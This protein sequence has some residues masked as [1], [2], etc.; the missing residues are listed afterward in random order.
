MD[1]ENKME[2]KADSFAEMFEDSTVV[3]DNLKPGDKVEAV[4]ARITDKWIFLDLGAKSEGCLEAE[5]L[6]DK[7]ANLQV[8]EGDSV[9]A[10]FLRMEDGEMVFTTRMS[11]SA[12]RSHLQEVYK[13][14][15]PVEGVIKKEIKGGFEV[16][17]AGAVR[18]FCPYSQVSLRRVDN[19]ENFVNSEF[20]FRIIEYKENGR[21]I[22]LSHRR[23]L[24]EEQ[25][26][27]K[28]KLKE[29]LEKG[30]QVTGT[31]TSVQQFG[32]FVDIGGIEGLIPASEISW[33]YLSDIHAALEV[34]QQVEV[35][36]MK[37]DWEN[38]R[39]SFSLKD[40]LPDPWNSLT[41]QEGTCLEG[42]VVRLV[43]FGVFVNLSPGIDG[44]VHISKLGAG[45]RINHPREVVK[46]GDS[47]EVCLDSIDLENRR[48]S[49]SLPN[50][51]EDQKQEEKP[52]AAEKEIYK[53]YKKKS[54]KS[55]ETM[56]TLGDILKDKLD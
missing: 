36:I 20:T 54:G 52:E 6:K 31:I 24:E 53:K 55:G 44:L 35:T 50:P 47:L 25:A 42:K 9:S 16:M 46:T 45:R 5:E 22:I 39:F 29:V 32:A 34:G 49:L 12:S 38:D 40:T 1:F 3:Q 18:A 10:W 19:P 51:A 17:I 23:I 26:R 14:G 7:E 30:Q 37:L 27:Q 56:G 33:E 8:R 28:E 2:D 13:S 43:D 11:G 15:I 4:I 21:N 41:L 48:I